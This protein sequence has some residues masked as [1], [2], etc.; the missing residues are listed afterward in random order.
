VEQTCDG[1]L[2]R[3]RTE[4]KLEWPE[5]SSAFDDMS[6]PADKTSLMWSFAGKTQRK[7]ERHYNNINHWMRPSEI[8]SS[9]N[10]WGTKGIRPAAIVQG[11]L[12]DCWFLAAIS[13]IAEWP[14]RLQKIFNGVQSYPSNG[15]FQLNFFSQGEKFPVTIDDKLPVRNTG[16]SLINTGRSTNGAWW[17]PLAEKAAAKF[18]GRY[19]NMYWGFQCEAFHV[20]TGM[21]TTYQ[22][23]SSFSVDQL[24]E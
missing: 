12:D 15:Q 18:Y 21:P 13:G 16:G 3:L 9:P 5:T 23:H 22:F 11:K 4:A 7:M 24:W 1:S 20:L 17:G 2:N 10:L 19:E 8:E 6:F 14:D